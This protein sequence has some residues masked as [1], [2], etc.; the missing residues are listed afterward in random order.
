[1][2]PSTLV[3]GPAIRL[4]AKVDALDR[5]CKRLDRLMAWVTK[6]AGSRADAPLTRYIEALKQ[7][8]EQDLEPPEGGGVQILQGVAADRRVSIEDADMRHGRKSKRKRFNG[9]KQHVS[10]DID[11]ELILGCAVTPANRPEEEATASLQEDM[12]RQD[13]FPDVLLIDRAYLN[14]AT[15][16]AV[17]ASGWRRHV[18]PVARRRRQAWTLRQARLQGERPS[19]HHHV[20]R[21]ATTSHFRSA[22]ACA[23][24]PAPGAR[25]SVTASMSASSGAGAVP[26]S[27]RAPLHATP[28]TRLTKR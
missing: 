7:V 27:Q 11:S 18:P 20:P 25:S 28:L 5:L 15:T 24:K 22:C 8:R 1:M 23:S 16:E 19:Q 4:D 26:G 10:T 2:L 6:Q 21:G 12:A 9:Y 3:D 17:L 14:S 13:L